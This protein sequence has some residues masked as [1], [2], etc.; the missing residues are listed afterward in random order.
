MAPPKSSNKGRS[1]S[2]P[3][4]SA[5]IRSTTGIKTVPLH[6]LKAGVAGVNIDCTVGNITRVM[7]QVSGGHQKHKFSASVLPVDSSSSSVRDGPALSLQEWSEVDQRAK[8]SELQDGDVVLITMV[9]CTANK[10]RYGSGSFHLAVTKATNITVLRH[11]SFK[12]PQLAPM[13]LAELKG[14]NLLV[15]GRLVLCI[16]IMGHVETVSRKRRSTGDGGDHLLILQASAYDETGRISFTAYGSHAEQLAKAGAG[17]Y[18]SLQDGLY[19]AGRLSTVQRSRLDILGSHQVPDSLKKMNHKTIQGL[20]APLLANKTLQ[21]L[22]E[23]CQAAGSNV[24]GNVPIIIKSCH[25]EVVPAC[26]SCYSKS[27]QLSMDRTDDDNDNSFVTYITCNKCGTSTPEAEGIR[28]YKAMMD[29][30]DPSTGK[31]CHGVNVTSTQAQLLT[32]MAPAAYEAADASQ[33]AVATHAITNK[34]FVASILA[35]AWKDNPGR[36]NLLLLEMAQAIQN[37]PATP[38]VD[39]EI[40][41]GTDPLPFA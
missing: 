30:E 38:A 1:A 36:V 35:S 39:K 12:L 4:D 6:F 19:K 14:D 15:P 27:V 16:D 32:M 37:D 21:S 28:A 3:S 24:E 7:R 10:G 5:G 26:G 23:Q 40:F 41:T 8:T 11:G 25:I 31:I 34:R 20:A 29:V 33:Q 22:Q 17:S 9:N 2:T 18:C 13:Q